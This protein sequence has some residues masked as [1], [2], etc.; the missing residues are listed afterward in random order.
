M[1]TTLRHTLNLPTTAAAQSSQHSEFDYDL[2][3]DPRYGIITNIVDRPLED[4]VPELMHAKLAHVANSAMLGQWQGDRIAFGASYQ[5]PDL[6]R[7]A[8]IGEAIERYCGNYIPKHLKRASY[9]QLISS[10]ESAIAPE[11][12]VLYAPQQHSTPGFPFTP[13]HQDQ[14]ICWVIADDMN[15]GEKVWVPASL[16]YINY[17]TGALRDEP[18]TNFVMYSGIA[19]GRGRQDAERSALEEL[20]ERDATMIWWH[21]GSPAVGIEPDSIP[22]FKNW[23]RTRGD[24]NHLLYQVVQIRNVFNVPVMGV[25]LNDQ[26]D[27]TVT[28]GVACRPN[29]K[30]AIQ[31]ALIEA[32]QLRGFAQGLLDPNGSVWQAMGAGILDARVYKPYRADRSYADAYRSDYHDITDLGCQSQFYLD[33]RTHQYTERITAPDTYITLDQVDDLKSTDVRA[34]YLALLQTQGMRALSVDVTTPDVALSGLSVVRVLVPGLYPNAP[35]GF[36]CLGGSRLYQEP[37]RLGWLPRALD[38]ND[39]VLHP[40]P[41]S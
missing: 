38:Y 8:A 4:D 34:A 30:A 9:K 22:E 12:W 28:F 18:Q 20:L 33:P 7:Y 6:A 31:K 32:V 39:L 37:V 15:S 25:L 41:H 24:S 27:Q 16:V 19:A 10:G 14:T 35:A 29:A 1:S 13:M 5:N 36:P 40:L 3:C 23:I 17:F 26:R 2:L 11:E 21:S